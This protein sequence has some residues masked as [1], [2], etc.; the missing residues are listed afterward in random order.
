MKKRYIKLSS[1]EEK[2]LNR[3]K[4][5]SLSSRVRE[6]SHSILLSNKGYSMASLSSIFEVRRATIS[7]WLDRWDKEGIEGLN[8]AYKS[9]RPT[10]FNEEE[11]KK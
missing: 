6:R 5:E 10:S 7:A 9:G 2:E 3:L 11:Q 1:A 8:D 4:K